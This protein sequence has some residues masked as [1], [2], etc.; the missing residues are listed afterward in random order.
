MAAVYKPSD[1][2]PILK[3]KS[4]NLVLKSS[5]ANVLV[6]CVKG[7]TSCAIDGVTA[8]LKSDWLKNWRSWLLWMT[9]FAIQISHSVSNSFKLRVSHL[10][11]VSRFSALNDTSTGSLYDAFP[12]ILESFIRNIFWSILTSNN[13]LDGVYPFNFLRLTISRSLGLQQTIPQLPYR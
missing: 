3:L 4:I 13:W 10:T 11:V 1:W 7:P 5:D 9:D 6:P 2:E 12:N 8:F